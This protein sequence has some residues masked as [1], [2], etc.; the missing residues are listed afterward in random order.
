MG[1]VSPVPLWK[2]M[3]E[4]VV[5]SAVI[6]MLSYLQILFSFPSSALCLWVS[7]FNFMALAVFCAVSQYSTEFAGYS[8][9]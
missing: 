7:Y 3:W 8:E 6:R 1:N 4:R 5:V 2:G 9:I